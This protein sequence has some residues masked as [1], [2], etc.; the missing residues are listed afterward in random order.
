MCRCRCRCRVTLQPVVASSSVGPP[1][2]NWRH[3]L[4]TPIGDVPLR[5]AGDAY[6]LIVSSSFEGS[7]CVNPP[8][9]IYPAWEE[10]HV[11]LER[12]GSSKP[13]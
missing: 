8:K 7:A 10:H 4:E 12:M 1:H 13:I 11:C 5:M 3:R 9:L 2:V 6:I